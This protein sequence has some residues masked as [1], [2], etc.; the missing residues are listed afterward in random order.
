MLGGHF[1]H[2]VVIDGLGFPVDAVMHE[3]EQPT[4]EADLGTVG[5]MTAMRE[6]H[7]Q[8]RVPRFQQG[9]VGSHVGLRPRVRLDVG[10][11][12]AEQRQ[13]PVDGQLF[14]AI[15]KF[16]SAIV[17]FLRVTLGILVGQNAAL[18]RH[19]GAAGDIFRCDQFQVGL[20]PLGFIVD[21]PGDFRIALSN[22]VG[23]QVHFSLSW[24]GHSR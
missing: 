18:G 24:S 1:G 6:I 19:D 23:I 5:Q 2:L 7:A 15:D 20:L 12:G 9:E 10:A 14:R 16:T 17:A 8:N 3:V 21:D 11:V 4:G 22:Q 13:G